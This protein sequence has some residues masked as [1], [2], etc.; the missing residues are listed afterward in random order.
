[1]VTTMMWESQFGASH[2]GRAAAVLDD[3]S[4][5]KPALFD[6][7]S[8]ADMYQ[9]SDWWVY[10]GTLSTPQASALRAACSC[11]WR[12]EEQFTIDWGHIDPDAPDDYDVSGPYGA[13]KRHV[14]T[15]E[16]QTVPL[17]ADVQD[18]L[19]QVQ[20]RLTAL[21]EDAPV[22]ALR[23]I[24]TLEETLADTGQS[25][26]LGVGQ[27]DPDWG[28]IATKLGL[29]EADCRARLYKYNLY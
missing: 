7:G 5:P 19:E 1:M 20:Q 13:W 23:A 25:A 14:D 24:A 27:D 17:P 21:A 8:S 6:A 12:G 29:T 3:G 4:E 10:D 2:E 16:R 28:A 18:L 22:A 11:G 26:A 15:V 9:T